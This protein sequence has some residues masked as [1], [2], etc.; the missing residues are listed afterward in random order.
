MRY[1]ALLSII[2]CNIFNVLGQYAPR[3]GMPGSTAIH[4]ESLDFVAW[5]TSCE[6]NRGPMTFTNPDSGLASVGD[7][8]AA[9]GYPEGSV[10]SL[11][12]GGS[13]TLRFDMPIRNNLGYDFV[14]FENGFPIGNAN[15]SDYLELAFVEV[16]TD[17]SYF[18]RF[19]ALSAKDT[20]VQ[21]GSFAGSKSSYYHNLAGKYVWPYGVPFDLD[22][23]KNDSGIDIYNINYVRIADVGGSLFE[24]FAS[25]DSKGDKI[26]DP[27][28][29]PFN[30]SGFD[31][32]AVGI[33]KQGVTT[34]GD[35]Y[36]HNKV[37]VFP[38]PI[39]A[40]QVLN[41]LSKEAITWK[42]YTSDGKC[43]NSGFAN[44]I[45]FRSSG[46][47]LLQMEFKDGSFQHTK[48]I[49]R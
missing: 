5:A 12:D 4:R 9:I 38:N 23:L 48:I 29:T 22:V 32:D 36:E 27:W 47:Y 34:V 8:M 30:S 37:Q 13:A 45:D 21:L 40:G 10:I 20:T 11:G 19:P 41:L 33:L 15:D 18:V 24:Q 2:C 26:N 39:S 49:V 46:L 35:L 17:G 3:P 6:I 25:R 1:L 28:P 7:A 42:V 31:L 16:S 43:V 14:V 44:E